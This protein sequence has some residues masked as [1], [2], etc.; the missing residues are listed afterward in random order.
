MG[1]MPFKVLE[2]SSYPKVRFLPKGPASYQLP[3]IVQPKV[4]IDIPWGQPTIYLA[5]TRGLTHPL[6]S[7]QAASCASG[8]A[9]TLDSYNAQLPATSAGLTEAGTLV[10]HSRTFIEPTGRHHMITSC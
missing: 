2:T 5:P 7:Y 8:N 4:I 9:P 3:P 10:I 6:G 1:Q